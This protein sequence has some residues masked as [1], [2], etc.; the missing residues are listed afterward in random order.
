MTQIDHLVI[1]AASLDAGRAWMETRLGVPATGAGKHPAMST[2]NALWRVGECY[3][4][5]IAVDPNAPD[6]GRPRWFGLDDPRVQAMLADG[7]RLLTWVARVPDMDAA[8]ER[9]AYDPG[10]ALAFTRDALHWQLTVPNDGHPAHEGRA[11]ALIAWDA[12]STPPSDSLPDQGVSL[13]SLSVRNDPPAVQALTRS[14]LDHLVTFTE[15]DT[16]L[17]AML[18]TPNGPVVLS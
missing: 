9:V 12:G 15:Q 14:G 16:P 3:M 1:G 11:P 5:V 7:P 13:A 18:N 4:E 17:V 8:L 2:H 6:V 10:P